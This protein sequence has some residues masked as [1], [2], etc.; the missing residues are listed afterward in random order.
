MTSLLATRSPR[1]PI[2][3]PRTDDLH[4]WERNGI[5]NA[6]AAVYKDQIVLL[7]RAYDN[8]RLSRLGIA[9]SRDGV[10]FQLYDHP[11]ID[12]DPYD[13]SERIGLED[14]RITK[15]D[16]TYYIVHT[17]ASY[18]RIGEPSDMHAT[19]SMPWRVRTGMH[20]TKDFKTYTHWGPILDVPSKNSS[21]LPVKFGDAFGL[22]YRE[23][24][25]DKEVLKVGFTKD[26]KH[27]FD[28]KVIDWP[29]AVEWQK[30]RFGLGSQALETDMG[31]LMVYHGVDMKSVYRLGLMLFDREDPSK[32]LWYTKEPILEPE[33]VY[34]TTGY[35]PNVVY[36]CGAVIVH[37]EL[38]IYYG[39]ADRVI[40]RAIL[41]MKDIEEAIK[42]E[43]SQS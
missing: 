32:L 33:E 29:P 1:E 21:L 10:H 28:Q 12:T 16:D 43:M 19:D 42:E 18:K 40:G 15:V 30:L 13:P 35:V 7:Y 36:T 23:Y 9:T 17:S 5:F 3:V 24:V 11:A 6:G 14:P 22:Y 8:Y 37:G 20:S 38:W 26:F 31:L 4:W 39:G 34:E 25:N 27:W 2:I 41:P